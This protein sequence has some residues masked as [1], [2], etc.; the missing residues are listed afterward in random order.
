MGMRPLGSASQLEERRQRAIALLRGGLSY[1][2]VAEQVNASLS[3]VVRWH[4]TFRKAGQ[5]GL[6]PKPV[7]GRPPRLTPAQIRALRGLLSAG[8]QQAGYATEL[9]TLRRVA[10]QIRTRFGVHYGLGG[11]RYVLLEQLEWSWQKPER[12]AIQRD[13]PAIAHWKRAVWP[14]IKKSP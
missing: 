5:R 14:R 12:R 1:R 13:E 6:R 11:A 2:A 9:W 3:S 7:P 4:Q 8:A 10:E